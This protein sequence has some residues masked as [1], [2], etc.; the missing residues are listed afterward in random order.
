MAELFMADEDEAR[1]A[2]AAPEIIAI[3]DFIL[4]NLRAVKVAFRQT[5]D[6]MEEAE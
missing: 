3:L 4:D 1:L 5:E 2:A 6:G